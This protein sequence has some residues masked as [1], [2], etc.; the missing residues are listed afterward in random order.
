[1][2]TASGLIVEKPEHF[3]GGSKKTKDC[4]CRRKGEFRCGKHCKKAH[5]DFKKPKR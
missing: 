5:K 4:R 1:M 2:T 3:Y